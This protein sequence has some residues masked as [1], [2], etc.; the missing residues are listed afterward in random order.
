MDK[1]ERVHA[2]RA[3]YHNLIPHVQCYLCDVKFD[4]TD[5]LSRAIVELANKAKLLKPFING[6]DFKKVEELEALL[7][8][9]IKLLDARD[10]ILA[11]SLK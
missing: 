9:I 1:K 11:L 7:S 4:P 10:I 5:Q 2:V 8:D 3:N 6:N